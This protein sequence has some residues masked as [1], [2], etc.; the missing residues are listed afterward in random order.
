MIAVGCILL[1]LFTIVHIRRLLFYKTATKQTMKLNNK[2]FHI[3]SRINRIKLTQ[4]NA[5]I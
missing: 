1:L 3:N 4:C 2:S 5:D